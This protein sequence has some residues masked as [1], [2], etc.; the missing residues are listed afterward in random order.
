M[1]ELH[2]VN[3]HLYQA[4]VLNT[5]ALEYM[6]IYVCISNTAWFAQALKTPVT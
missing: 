3:S 6:S 5:Q 1:R 4:S 2:T